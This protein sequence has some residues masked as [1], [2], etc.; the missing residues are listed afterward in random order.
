MKKC[1]EHKIIQNENKSMKMI[2][3][4]VPIDKDIR[5]SPK[6]RNRALKACSVVYSTKKIV[7]QCVPL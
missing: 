3:R 2:K 7:K 6:G 1:I 4:S 5:P